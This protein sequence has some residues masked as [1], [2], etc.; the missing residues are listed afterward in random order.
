MKINSNN[1]PETGLEQSLNLPSIASLSNYEQYEIEKKERKDLQ[2]RRKMLE[3][4]VATL[5]R[6]AEDSTKKFN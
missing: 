2:K 1:N 6:E 3:E 4:A 5:R